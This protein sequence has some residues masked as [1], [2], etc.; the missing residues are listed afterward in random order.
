MAVDKFKFVSPGIFIEEIDETFIPTLPE[1][2]GPLVV[3]R[4]QKGPGLRPVKVDSFQDFVSLFGAP[5]AG[6]PSGD[7]WRTGEMTAPTYA[8]YA[9]QAW[10]AN[11]S[12]CT[13]YRLLGEQSTN[14]D[15]SVTTAEAGWK[16]TNLLGS[17]ISSSGGAYGL[18]VMPNPDSY[19]TT[20]SSGPI[21]ISND[22]A[23]THFTIRVPRA[24]GGPG[25]DEPYTI[26]IGTITGSS[27]AND[28]RVAG[29]SDAATMLGRLRKLFNEDV[30]A[31]TTNYQLGS[32]WNTLM[33]PHLSASFGAGEESVVGGVSGSTLVLHTVKGGWPA[34]ATQIVYS[35]GWDNGTAAASSLT[36]SFRSGSSGI[37]TGTLA[38]IWYLNQGAVVLTGTCRDG[39]ARQGAGVLMKSTDQVFTAKVTTDGNEEGVTKT[40]T[41]NFDPDSDKYIRKVFNTD[42]TKTNSTLVDTTTTTLEKYWLGET[43]DTCVRNNL[44]KKSANKVKIAG[45]DDQVTQV[46]TYGESESVTSTGDFLGVIFGLKGSDLGVEWGDHKQA[47]QAAKTGWF[48]SQDLR[49]TTSTGFDPKDPSHVE[50]LFR[51]VSL[52]SGEHVNRDYKVSI[53]DI[54]QPSDKYNAYGTFTV[55]FR[56]ASDTD[57]KPEVVERYTNVDL[58]PSSPRFIKRVIGDRQYSYNSANKTLTELG[59][60]PNISKICRVETSARVDSA[61]AEGMLPYGVYGPAVPKTMKLYQTSSVVDIVDINGNAV[62]PW[63]VSSGTIP[64]NVIVSPHTGSRLLYP[65]DTDA[66]GVAHDLKDWQLTASIEWPRARLRVSSSEGNMALQTNAYFGYASTIANTRRYDKTNLDL[67]RGQPANLDMGSIGGSTK[68][69]Y[70]WI[71]TLDDIKLR[72]DDTSEALWVSGSRKAGESLTATSGTN[73]VLDNKWNKFTSPFFGGFDG[74]DIKE[75]DPLSNTYIGTNAA[76]NTNYAFYSIQKAIDLAADSE[77]MEFDIATIPGIKNSTLTKALV[78]ACEDRADA[79]AIIDLDGDYTPSHENNSSEANRLG[80]VSTTKTN[81]KDM[82]INSS[83]G[84]AFYPYV[85]VRDTINDAVLDMPPSVVALGTFSSSQRKSAVWFAPAGFTRGGLTEGSAGLPVVGVKQRLTSDDRDDLYSANINPIASFPAEGVVIFGQK[86][87]QVTRSSLDRIN[88]RRLLIFLK[89]EISR[90]ASRILFEQNVEATWAKFRGQ[91]I[92]FLDSVEAGLGLTDYKLVLDST[93]TTPDLIDRNVLYAK[94]FLKPARAIE[95]IALDFIISKSGASFDD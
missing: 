55:I 25:M 30:S 1:R 18:F 27:A 19:G 14:A 81:L 8:A 36:S 84:C 89:K 64:D 5:A 7:T 3:G 15:T 60:Y 75:K 42:P 47:N 33:R 90:I 4:F 49:G 9:V 28:V 37:V 21:A 46:E 58:N 65:Y 41:F 22:Y 82:A 12:P 72:A 50:K 74:F 39:A 20:A 32:N 77:Y 13:V 63:I 26:M 79:L 80:S 17:E 51:F 53:T 71:F 94:I 88:V 54:R 29:A 31:D 68:Q 56:T 11:N 38:A 67:F 93:T 86:T 73:A 76:V 92:P 87:L 43:F 23:G 6:I 61:G 24:I 70:S 16:T 40:A 69:Q 78:N 2:M 85:K 34:N 83:Y 91:V 48:F 45:P 57:H 35:A 44:A 59:D 95:F 66:P 62:D 10:M 52:D